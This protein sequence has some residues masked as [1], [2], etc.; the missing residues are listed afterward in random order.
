MPVKDILRIG[1]AAY[2][3][4]FSSVATL[5]HKIK[6]KLGEPYCKEHCFPDF[7]WLKVLYLLHL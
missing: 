4:Q 1:F 5:C 6:I 3:D 2:S 7:I